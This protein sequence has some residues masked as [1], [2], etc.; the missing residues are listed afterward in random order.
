MKHLLIQLFILLFLFTSS[1]QAAAQ[2][3]KKDNKSQSSVLA[4]LHKALPDE[5]DQNE[6]LMLDG[7][8]IPVYSE[9]LE[10]LTG[11]KMMEYMMSGDYLP[12]PYIDEQK[13]VKLFLLRKATE[14]EKNRIKQVMRQNQPGGQPMIG[15]DAKNFEVTDING[16]SYTLEGLKGKVVVLNFWFVECKPCIMEMPEL[17]KLTEKFNQ[18]DVVF[19]GL[20]TSDENKIK[21]FLKNREF[22]YNLV[23]NTK[24]IA[25]TYQVFGFP[26]HVIIDKAGKI[27]FYVTGLGP[28]TM[29]DLEKGIEV[30]L[31]EK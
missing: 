14:E 7:V 17:N 23:A 21:N 11:D 4:G 31:E 8:T 20:A 19:L 25:D 5:L 26:S 27:T 13:K 1:F 30:L 10:K 12:E 22:K 16:N 28:S 2:R 3:N 29:A 15:Q 24:A 18:S 9:N 6:P